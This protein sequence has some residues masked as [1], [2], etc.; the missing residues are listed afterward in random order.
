MLKYDKATT[1]LACAARGRCGI[2]LSVMLILALV[3]HIVFFTVYADL[4]A[5]GRAGRLLSDHAKEGQGADTQQRWQGLQLT[6]SPRKHQGD[7][8]HEAPHMEVNVMVDEVVEHDMSRSDSLEHHHLRKHGDGGHIE[9]DMDPVSDKRRG[10]HPSVHRVNKPIIPDEVYVNE[11]PVKGG[12]SMD[13]PHGAHHAHDHEHQPHRD[14]PQHGDHGHPVENPTPAQGSVE[15]QNPTDFFMSFSATSTTPLPTEIMG[16]MSTNA[17]LDTLKAGSSSH[18]PFAQ[19]PATDMGED[20]ISGAA[21]SEYIV[22]KERVAAYHRLQL[23]E[24]RRADH[25]KSVENRKEHGV[26]RLSAVEVRVPAKSSHS[27]KTDE[28]SQSA[29]TRKNGKHSRRKPES[30]EEDTGEDKMSSRERRKLVKEAIR[31]VKQE[32][33]R[34]KLR[35]KNDR[36]SGKLQQA[37]H[38]LGGIEH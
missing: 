13:T 25:T 12:G 18:L 30:S 38:K 28:D 19:N 23:D 16:E 2:A 4:M 26:H 7:Q 29:E 27:Q 1:T 36:L 10:R 3:A 24:D 32:E 22:D 14:T 35:R 37:Q 6:S 31:R 34:E 5:F 17:P 9:R 8:G 11:Y 33:R 15:E 20:K 21:Y